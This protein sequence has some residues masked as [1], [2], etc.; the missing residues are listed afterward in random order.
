VI[1]QQTGA[2]PYDIPGGEPFAHDGPLCS[3]DTIIRHFTIRDA[4]LGVAVCVCSG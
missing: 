2:I 1:A 4:A 3:F